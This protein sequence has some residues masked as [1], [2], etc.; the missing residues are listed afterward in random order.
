MLDNKGFDLWANEYDKTVGISDSDGTYPFAGYK[1]ILNEIYNSI[2]NNSSK[3]VLDIG[4]GTG[5]L[6]AKLYE[7]GCNIYGQDFSNKMVELAKNK[8]PKAK[9]FRGDF[10]KGLVKELKE[11]KYDVIIATYSLHHL[12][13]KE[14]IEFIKELIKLLNENSVIYIGD[15]A[16]ETRSDL[17]KCK[18]ENAVHWDNDEIYFV[19]DEIKK[20][21]VN[22]QFIKYSNCAGIIKIW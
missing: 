4:F 19:Y 22:S 8:M 9:L 7:K 6:T 20:Y 3:N 14:K 10:T 21:F 15:V 17:E 1:K 11:Q 2:L 16:F 5:T 12:T 13:D 18:E